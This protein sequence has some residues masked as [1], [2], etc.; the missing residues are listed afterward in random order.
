MGLQREEGRGVLAGPA[1][2]GSPKP[3]QELPK[4]LENNTLKEQQTHQFW[5]QEFGS[6]KLVDRDFYLLLP[7]T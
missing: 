7:K 4:D 1:G 3:E 2:E 5:E 6:C